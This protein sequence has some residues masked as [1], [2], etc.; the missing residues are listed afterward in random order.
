MRRI[1]R[2]LKQLLTGRKEEHRALEANHV[3]SHWSGCPEKEK[4]RWSFAK[5]RKSGDDGGAGSSGQP[6]AGA[7]WMQQVRAA[8][9]G[10]RAREERAAVVIQKTFR[11]YLARRALRALRSLVKIQALVR[12]Y[13]VR[14]QAAM[15]LQRLQTLMRL[16]A[17]SIAVKNASYR[18]SMEQE[19]RIFAAPEVRMKPPATPVHRRRLS[20]STDSNYERSPRIVE[21]DTCHLRSRSSR[22]TSRHSPA[23]HLLV[24]H[25]HRP[26]APTPSCSPLRGAK[27]QPARLSFRRSTHERDPRGAKTAH[28]TPRFS[29]HDSSPAKSVEH[30]QAST[31]PRSASRRD[32]DA[33]V[34]P[35]YMAGTASSAAR[36]RCHSAPRQRQTVEPEAAP[37]TSVT[38]AGAC[39]GSCSHEHGGG[40]CFHCSDAIRPAG[41]SRISASD[42]VA[43]DYYLDSFW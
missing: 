18:K 17:D 19:E 1:R 27:Q 9:E 22:I 26:A 5:Q 21:M 11:G 4:R 3:G 39:S 7:E 12:G 14:K 16:Q 41:F 8:K 37:R 20:D 30:S 28:N 6:A 25:R 13:L 23:D 34:S 33:L 2:W 15:T 38:R 29:T 32:R 42:E 43:R 36:T 10:A 31:P 35:R 24:Y 40:F